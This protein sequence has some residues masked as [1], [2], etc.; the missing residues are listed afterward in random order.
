MTLNDI[1]DG[2]PVFVDANIFIYHFGG[3]S[4]QCKALLERSE[5][6]YIKAMTGV[7]IILE[8]LHRL[9]TM[10]AIS[11]GLITPGQPAK[12]L[13]QNLDV[14]RRLSEYNHCVEDIR[15]M[16]VRIYPVTMKQVRSSEMV[17][18]LYGLMTNDSVTAAMMLNHGIVS[19]ATLDS[20][21]ARVPDLILYQPTDVP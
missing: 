2:A 7:H 1:P 14:I 21:L 6:Q 20:D 10:E 15:R 17:R 12:K 9:M 18:R 11:K 5:R 8:V 16:R 3:A 19:L 4:V 13:K